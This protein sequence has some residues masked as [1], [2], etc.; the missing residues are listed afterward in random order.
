MAAETLFFYHLESEE[1]IADSK[2]INGLLAMPRLCKEINLVDLQSDCGTPA[3]VAGR[4]VR[5]TSKQKSKYLSG[6]GK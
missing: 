2:E 5:R 3:T 1:S 4:C 6:C